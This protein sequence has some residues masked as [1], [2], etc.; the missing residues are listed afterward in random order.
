M[1]MVLNI[2]ISVAELAAS[3]RYCASLSVTLVRMVISAL[4]MSLFVLVVE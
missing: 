4:T 1:V 2:G 3:H